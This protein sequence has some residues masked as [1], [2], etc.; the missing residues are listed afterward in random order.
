MNVVKKLRFLVVGGSMSLALFMLAGVIQGS[1]QAAPQYDCSQK[2]AVVLCGLVESKNGLVH[3]LSAIK[4]PN[5]PEPAWFQP[6]RPVTRTVTYSVTSRGAVTTNIEEFA[7][8]AQETYDHPNGWIKLGVQF[9]RVASGGDFTLYLASADQMTTFSALGCDSTYSCQ[10]G[11]D[12]IINQ[13][14]WLY[15]TPAWNEGRG[16]LRDYRHM[17]VNHETGHWLGHGH[18]NC[19]SPGQPAPVMQQQSINLQGC[20][21][22]PWPLQ[23]ELYSS[24][25]GI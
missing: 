8:L 23:S 2:Q 12:V 13:D 18:Q 3:T 4:A 5:L 19:P 9:K 10:V 15:A 25:L 24:K 20:T 11:R 16:S 6:V 21:F 17:V 14:R 7:R 22:N 1:A